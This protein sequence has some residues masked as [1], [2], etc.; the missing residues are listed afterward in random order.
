MPHDLGLDP[1]AGVK[2]ALDWVVCDTKE[3]DRSGG[4]NNIACA[5]AFRFVQ[6]YYAC[7]SGGGGMQ[8][9]YTVAYGIFLSMQ[10][11]CIPQTVD[12][13]LLFIDP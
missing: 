7:H 10:C 3:L 1:L 5:P 12:A 13:H 6:A 9:P 8:L 11:R 4:A 2:P